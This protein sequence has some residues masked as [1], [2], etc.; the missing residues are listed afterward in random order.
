MKKLSILAAS[1]ALSSA[2]LASNLDVQPGQYEISTQGSDLRFS[3]SST[4]NTSF[5]G[6]ETS[7]GS[8]AWSA[9]VNG[10]TALTD[11]VIIGGTVSL[12]NGGL[13]NTDANGDTTKTSYGLRFTIA[14]E[15][16]YY[17]DRNIALLGKVLFSSAAGETDYDAQGEVSSYGSS[18]SAV[19]GWVGAK[20][21]MD[22]SPNILVSAQSMIGL[23]NWSMTWDDPNDD[24]KSTV[25]YLKWN[26]EVAGKY[27]V[28]QHFSVNGA[29][30]LNYT[31]WRSSTWNGSE[32]DLGDYA[33]STLTPG[34]STGFSVY[35]R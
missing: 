29:L 19:E 11:M 32:Q 27:F 28:N 25:S 5:S 33:N 9:V 15:V 17:L 8:N 22:Y 23:R 20:Y 35:F 30:Y 13:S 24:D 31:A 12:S 26:S 1:V 10:R 7:S 16:E 4:S 18:T 14:P 6:V 34:L 21:R 3:S 2:A